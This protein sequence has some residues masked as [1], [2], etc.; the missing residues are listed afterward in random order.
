MAII[1]YLHKFKNEL[2]LIF[3]LSRIATII[4]Y[5]YDLDIE[6]DD[7][8]YIS[9]SDAL[10]MEPITK[11]EIDVIDIN[12]YDLYIF[13]LDNTLYLHNVD[14]SYKEE[15]ESNLKYFLNYL[16]NNNKKLAIASHH[17]CPYIL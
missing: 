13:D 10:N 12:S 6:D 16:K 15:Y 7:D 3:K 8:D 1:G 17:S 4:M 9:F 5:F 11:I 2:L 14:P